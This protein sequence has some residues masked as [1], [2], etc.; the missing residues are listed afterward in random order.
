MILRVLEV[1]YLMS[2]HLSKDKRTY[3]SVTLG[4][5]GPGLALKWL[6]PSRMVGPTV[7]YF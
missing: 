1:V 6:D 3:N 7:G 5:T 2:V 4:Y